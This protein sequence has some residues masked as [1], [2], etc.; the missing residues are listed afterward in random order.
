MECQ[1]DVGVVATK[2]SH[3]LMASVTVV[4]FIDRSFRS[5]KNRYLYI[6]YTRTLLMRSKA[7]LVEFLTIYRLSYYIL[8]V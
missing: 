4:S 6:S 8:I 1:D 7:G 3:G 2:L 5:K